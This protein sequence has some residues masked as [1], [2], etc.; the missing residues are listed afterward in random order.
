MRI[1]LVDDEEDLARALA[2]LLRAERYEV[3]WAG[4]IDDAY[5]ALADGE[6]DLVILDVM[7][8]EGEAA[9]F[10]LARDLRDARVDI[11]VLFLTARDALEDRVEGLDLGGDDYLTKPF[12]TEE[13]LAR[14]RALL[15]RDGTQRTALLARGPL[16]ID[17]R[18]RVVRWAGGPVALSDREFALLETFALHP[19][20]AYAVEELAERH[21]PNAA[22]GPYVVRTYVFRL[23]RKLGPEAIRTLPGGYR[24]GV[25]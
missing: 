14:V 16:E 18:A 19:E 8:P 6:P 24:L 4:S 20:R 5:E 2:A 1:L 9:G 21:F 13:L 17:F 3:R 11:P 22:S 10:A 12:A 15:R 25:P 7:F 23:R